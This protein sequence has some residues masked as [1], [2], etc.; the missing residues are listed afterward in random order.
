MT[1]VARCLGI[2]AG[3]EIEIVQVCIES[4]AL[5]VVI[6][7]AAVEDGVANAEV[8][9]GGVAAR[10]AAALKGGDVG[11]AMRVHI[12]ANNGAVERDAV[13][14]PL[15]LEDR[16]NANGCL[17]VVELQQGRVCIGCGPFDGQTV[18]IELEHGEVQC[19]V[20]QVDRDTQ[21]F[22]GL[23]LNAA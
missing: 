22:G 20:L 9:D 16:H 21:G 7:F 3:A 10:L 17:G 2:E 12:D 18:Q 13:E 11:D 8:E 5:V 4:A 6:R 14:V 23:L 19:V 15:A 1:G